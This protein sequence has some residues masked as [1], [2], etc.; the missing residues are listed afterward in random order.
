MKTKHEVKIIITSPLVFFNVELSMEIK[1]RF[2][3][4]LDLMGCADFKRSE[5][6]CLKVT[7]FSH[8]TSCGQGYYNKCKKQ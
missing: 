8:Y 1:K 7:G 5:S 2:W 6:V 4:L 3:K